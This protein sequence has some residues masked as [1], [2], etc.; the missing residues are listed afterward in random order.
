MKNSMPTDVAYNDGQENVWNGEKYSMIFGTDVRAD[1][2]LF[3]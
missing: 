1:K 2:V 3:K